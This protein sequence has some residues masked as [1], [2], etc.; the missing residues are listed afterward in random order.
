ME[1]QVCPTCQGQRYVWVISDE[2][3]ATLSGPTEWEQ[4]PCPTCGGKG[5]REW[6]Q[7]TRRPRRPRGWGPERYSDPPGPGG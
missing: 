2:W 7:R 6:Q 4:V 1:R 5:Y 3:L